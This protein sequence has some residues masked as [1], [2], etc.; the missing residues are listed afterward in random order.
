M[1]LCCTYS[2]I[3]ELFVIC[4]YVDLCC[5]ATAS[6]V[7]GVKCMDIVGCPRFW[8][9]QQLCLLPSGIWVGD[10]SVRSSDTL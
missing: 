9:V 5:L 4:F 6:L 7:L 10:M 8:V 2:G 3:S 1:F